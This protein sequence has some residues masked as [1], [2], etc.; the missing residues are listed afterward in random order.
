[1]LR[2]LTDNVLLVLRDELLPAAL[3]RRGKVN[4]DE[5]VTRGVQVGLE[6]E[7][8]ALIGHILVLGVK[9]ID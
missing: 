6:R 1:M 7:Q 5:A 3:S 9:V 4:V 8:R 2:R